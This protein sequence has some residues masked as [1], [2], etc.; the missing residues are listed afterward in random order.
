MDIAVDRVSQNG[1][2][3]D[4]PVFQLDVQPAESDGKAPKR[5]PL[6]NIVPRKAV[7]PPAC[8]VR[9]DDERR[10]SEPRQVSIRDHVHRGGAVAHLLRH[11][12]SGRPRCSDLCQDC[13]SGEKQPCRKVPNLLVTY[14]C[15]FR[16]DWRC[17]YSSGAANRGIFSWLVHRGPALLETVPNDVDTPWQTRLRPKHLVCPCL[18]LRRNNGAPVGLRKQT[19]RP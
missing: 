8:N 13:R 19:R 9:R 7:A 16:R 10:R 1:P 5:R 3:N 17:R 18:S 14:T 12:N 2:S 4:P 15:H 6:E 11:R